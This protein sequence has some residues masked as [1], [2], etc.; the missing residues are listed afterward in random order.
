MKGLSRFF[1]F[2]LYLELYLSHTRNIFSLPNG[3]NDQ[4]DTHVRLVTKKKS[5][6]LENRLE[7]QL[8]KVSIKMYLRYAFMLRFFFFNST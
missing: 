2:F 4:V 3:I 8:Q 7:K 5:Q 6:W 1:S